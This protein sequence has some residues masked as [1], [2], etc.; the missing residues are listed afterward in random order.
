MTTTRTKRPVDVPPRHPRPHAIDRAD[1]LINGRLI[2]RQWAIELLER[3]RDHLAMIDH[4][5]QGGDTAAAR[6]AIVTADV[7]VDINARCVS[8]DLAGA[9]ALADSIIKRGK[10]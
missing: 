8:G 9:E 6:E 3:V 4:C 5:L 2:D 1:R 7:E 10:T